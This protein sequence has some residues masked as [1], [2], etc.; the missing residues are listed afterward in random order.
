[1]DLA[2]GC[3]WK[4]AVDRHCWV[5]RCRAKNA[6]DLAVLWRKHT[7][8]GDC[9]IKLQDKERRE[10]GKTDG[11]FKNVGLAMLEARKPELK[12]DGEAGR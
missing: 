10:A 6:R 1:M 8:L 12:D 4:A 7:K 11:I 5:S 2:S 3:E 9:Q